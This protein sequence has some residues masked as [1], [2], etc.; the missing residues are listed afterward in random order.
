MPNFYF[1]RSLP[2]SDLTADSI[3]FRTAEAT[4]F[5]SDGQGTDAMPEILIGSVKGP[6]GQAFA[7]LMGQTEGHT[8]M[9]AIRACNQQVRPATMIVPKVTIKSAAYVN[10][11]GGPVQSAIADA[12]LDSVIAGVI[13]KE[14]ANDLCIV[15]MVWIAPE[16]ATNPELDRKDL[17]RTNYEAMKLAISRAMSN[18]PSIDELIANRHSIVHEMYDPETGESQW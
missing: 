6:A 13:P 15:A 2:M 3:W 11:F 16:C 4:V 8:R 14:W 10:L 1:F 12:V 18:S 9:F 7:N 5:S 17:Y